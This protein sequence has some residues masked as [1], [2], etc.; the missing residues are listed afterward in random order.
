MEVELGES[1]LE[2]EL[3]GIEVRFDRAG[4]LLCHDVLF[5]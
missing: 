4:C 1:E 2:I 3:E 5:R